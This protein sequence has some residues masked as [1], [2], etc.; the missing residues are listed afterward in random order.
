MSRVVFDSSF[1]IA[2]VQKP[3]TWHEDIVAEIGAFDAVTLDCVREELARMAQKKNKRGR[4]AALAYELAAT[5]TE[6]ACGKGEPDDE[7]ISYASS[8]KASVATMDGELIR[9]LRA[10]R[11]GVITLRS[12][13]LFLT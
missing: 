3:T 2:V 12:G 5:F 11:V 13:R 7:I 6:E 1:L 8:K 10:L 4:Y 9:K